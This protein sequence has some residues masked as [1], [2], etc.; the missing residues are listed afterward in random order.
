M[1]RTRDTFAAMAL[2]GFAAVAIGGFLGLAIGFAVMLGT[3]PAED[4]DVP[5]VVSNAAAKQDRIDAA[6]R[7]ARE[8]PRHLR[9][10]MGE[11]VR[12]AGG[13]QRGPIDP[14]PA[15]RARE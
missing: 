1:R 4:T 13:D 6:A 9:G 15:I 14:G 5:P 11:P 10:E 12:D 3:A 8:A 7:H 2:G